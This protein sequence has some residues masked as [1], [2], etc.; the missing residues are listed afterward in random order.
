MSWPDH[1]LEGFPPPSS[2]DGEPAN[3]RRDILDELTDHLDCA[4]QRELRRSDDPDLARQTALDRFGNPRKIARRLWLDAMKGQ[5][6]NQRIMIGT[7]VLM[8]IV[9][10]VLCVTFLLTLRQNQ[11][12]QEA[13]MARIEAISAAVPASVDPATLASY[14]WPTF[15]LQALDENGNSG[16][17]GLKASLYG[18]PYNAG[19]KKRIN[20]TTDADGRAMFGPIRAGGYDLTVQGADGMTMT[21][22]V[23]VPPG[24]ERPALEIR[25]L[26]PP[27]ELVRISLH[28]DSASLPKDIPWILS[29]PMSVQ[30]A[31]RPSQEEHWPRPPVSLLFRSDGRV[32]LQLGGDHLGSISTDD[33]EKMSWGNDVELDAS[34]KYNLQQGDF[35][36]GPRDSSE[37]FELR[38]IAMPSGFT[39]WSI[40]PSTTS[41][42]QIEI[43]MNPETQTIVDRM[44]EQSQRNPPT[45][46]STTRPRTP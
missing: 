29:I 4:V 34:M 31:R 43:Q 11:R 27:P 17:S 1:I 2:S 38:S 25:W 8:I 5:L 36:L 9:I 16:L 21:R 19:E 41:H 10:T 14:D 18:E 30:P 40:E 12:M 35:L 44:I 24:P 26:N 20:A 22:S 45:R 39:P 13:L 46:R 42:P 37:S 28:L 33:L 7:Q 23:A 3:L 15:R 6:M 32:S